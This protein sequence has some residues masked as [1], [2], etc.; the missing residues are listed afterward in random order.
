MRSWFD[1]E[2]EAAETLYFKEWDPE[3]LEALKDGP[4]EFDGYLYKF[5]APHSFKRK[6]EIRQSAGGVYRWKISVLAAR[7]G[8]KIVYDTKASQRKNYHL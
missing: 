5:V 6:G 7:K 8:A 4:V 3:L 1:S 2:V